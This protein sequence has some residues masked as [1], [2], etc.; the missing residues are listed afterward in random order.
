MKEVVIPTRSQCKL[1]TYVLL[2][3]KQIIAEA[4]K[5]HFVSLAD[6]H[7]RIDFFYQQKAY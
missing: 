5:Q 6:H 1:A 7:C 4:W 3:A 2:V